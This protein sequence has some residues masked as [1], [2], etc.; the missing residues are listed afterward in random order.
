MK[1]ALFDV[2]VLRHP[3]KLA[4]GKYEEVDTRIVLK[5]QILAKDEKAA[6]F[7]VVRRIPE[8]DAADPETIEVLIRPF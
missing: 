8:A 3:K 4:D 5:D 6:G 1:L 7:L 2:V